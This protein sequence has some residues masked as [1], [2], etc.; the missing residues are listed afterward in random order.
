MLLKELCDVPGVSGDEGKIRALLKE[1]AA[2]VA[3]SVSVDKLGNIIAVKKASVPNAPK[4]M[5]MAHMDEVGFIIKSIGDDGLLRYASVGGIDP[6]VAVSKRVFI[7]EDE[8][9]GVIG[10]KPIHLQ[11]EADFGSATKHKDMYIDIGATTKDEAEKLVQVGDYAHF[12][13]KLF[14]FGDGRVC[15]KAID[16]RVGCY[17]MLELMKNNYPVEM[18][19]V[20]TVSEEIGMIGAQVLPHTVAPDLAIA[21]EGTTANDVCGAE[22]HQ[23]VVRQKKGPAISFMDG[24]SIMHKG[25]FQNLLDIGLR[26]E[27]PVQTKNAVAGGT[28]VGAVQRTAGALP[29][30]TISVPCRYIHAPATVCALSDIDDT[31]R[32]L[33]VFLSTGAKYTR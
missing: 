7:G 4:L 15:A 3:D 20:F 32:L 29:A 13:N 22:Y 23:Q 12:A 31:I 5:F 25:L 24:R 14:E 16:D 33:H 27:I 17:I 8:V 10:A 6:R 19:C 28:D 9:P 11:S 2:A 26:H 1:K 30:I 18:H 21:L